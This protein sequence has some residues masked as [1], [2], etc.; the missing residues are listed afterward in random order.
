MIRR[1]IFAMC[2]A[3]CVLSLSCSE[4]GL[5]PDYSSIADPKA[6]WQAYGFTDYTIEQILDCFCAYGGIPIKV[7]VRN[8]QVFNIF[9]AGNGLRLPDAY[10]GQFRT[11]DGL[12]DEVAAVD[13]DSVSVFT[14]MYDA[15]YGF[16]T[17]IY[18]D[19]SDSLAD[20]EYGFR[21]SNFELK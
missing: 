15:K 21:T 17:V 20:E 5:E 6:R 19:P 4:G 7:V 3:C 1:F 8:S 12:F 10:W 13:P 18:V 11:I 16:P 2:T 14:V 9:Q